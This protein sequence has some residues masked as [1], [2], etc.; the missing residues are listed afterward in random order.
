MGTPKYRIN[1]EIK[2]IDHEGNRL[3]FEKDEIFTW[4]QHRFVCIA[5]GAQVS[6]AKVR[7][8]GAR[9]IPVNA[10][11]KDL[12]LSEAGPDT[13]PVESMIPVRKPVFSL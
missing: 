11:L 4:N 2:I 12:D 13:E 1:K 9:M 10:D 6:R 7:D 8:A 5:D 3:K